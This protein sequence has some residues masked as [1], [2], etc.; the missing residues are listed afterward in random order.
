LRDHVPIQPPRPAERILDVSLSSPTP[1]DRYC[2]EVIVVITGIGI[3]L[4]RLLQARPSLLQELAAEPR[5][6]IDPRVGGELR[7]SG[8]LCWRQWQ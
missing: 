8:A 2:H 6:S 5:A 1:V 3:K 7:F 4:S